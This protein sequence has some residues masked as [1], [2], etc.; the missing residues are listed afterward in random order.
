VFSTLAISV[1]HTC[2]E[3]RN[4]TDERGTFIFTLS[5]D[6][7][8]S[9]QCR[10]SLTIVSTNLAYPDSRRFQL[11]NPPNFHFLLSRPFKRMGIP[12]V[13]T[14]KYPLRSTAADTRQ[15]GLTSTEPLRT[16]TNR[17]QDPTLTALTLTTT[18]QYPSLTTLPLINKQQYP[19]VTN[20]HHYPTALS[21]SGH[22]RQYGVTIRRFG[23]RFPQKGMR[24][25]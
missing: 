4:A 16:P 25:T 14:M 1:P 20:R 18:K 2:H 22:S 5:R 23:Y 13:S 8:R 19:T 10:H 24:S 15:G 3:S 7:C 6:V 9:L 17:L 12:N 21:T 11:T